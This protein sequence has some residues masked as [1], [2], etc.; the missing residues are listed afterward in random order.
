[1]IQIFTIIVLSSI[2]LFAYIDSDIDGVEDRYDLCPNTPLTQ[3]VNLEGCGIEDLSSS[4]HFDIIFGLNY[5]IDNSIKLS[6]SSLQLDYYYKNISI[7]VYSSYFNINSNNNI[8]SGFNKYIN[9]YYNFNISNNFLLRAKLGLSFPTYINSDTKI[10]YTSALYGIYKN[11]NI[12]LLFG[13][14]YTNQWF[15]NIGVGYYMTDKLY[16]SIEYHNSNSIFSSVSD[17]RALSIYSYYKLDE[18]W[19][20][21][22][23]YR[24][25]LSNSAIDN[26]FGLRLGYYW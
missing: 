9:G 12:T 6:T 3:L 19:F 18:H 16:T 10:D 20:F 1:M 21:T 14:G 11:E 23:N 8:Q 15:Y 26:S 2:F 7:E 4:K 24:Y 13:L 17:I 22:L 5:A 25:G